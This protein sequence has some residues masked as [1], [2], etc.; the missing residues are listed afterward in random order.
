MKISIFIDSF[1]HNYHFLILSSHPS[2]VSDFLFSHIDLRSEVTNLL[3][4]SLC[5]RSNSRRVTVILKL[6][7]SQLEEAEWKV[8][9]ASITDTT[10][11]LTR[12]IIS[13]TSCCSQHPARCLAN[14]YQLPQHAPL[15][16]YIKPY[17]GHDNQNSPRRGQSTPVRS[18]LLWFNL[19]GF[20]AFLC[21]PSGRAAY[22]CIA[23]CTGP[24]RLFPGEGPLR[25]SYRSTSGC[26]NMCPC[27]GPACQPASDN[28]SLVFI[29]VRCWP[30]RGSC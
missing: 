25:F 2:A 13:P 29:S 11:E 7:Y 28:Y 14:L 15:H 4:S 12:Y 8:Y 19:E 6:L 26:V 24:T 9:I 10:L 1:V 18:V 30:A 20:S 27:S 5:P 22:P 17:T 21:I 23:L 3:H 16:I